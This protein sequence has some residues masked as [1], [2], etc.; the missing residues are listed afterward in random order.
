MSLKLEIEYPETLPVALQESKEEF[1][2]EARMA[3]AS[4][5]FEL[6]RISSGIAAKIAGIKRKDFLL[7]LSRYA[8]SMIDVSAEEILEDLKIFHV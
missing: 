8:V 6:K 7:R 3:L 4:K 5:L 1:E 2:K